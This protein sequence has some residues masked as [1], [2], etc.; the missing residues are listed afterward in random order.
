MEQAPTIHV[1]GFEIRYHKNRE[2]GAMDRPVE[3]VRYS[4]RFG[5]QSTE[6]SKP[7][8]HILP[9]EAKIGGGEQN[10]NMKLAFMRQRWNMIE[11]AYKAWKEGNELPL[12]GTPL[13]VWP[14]V[15]QQQATA[16]KN[17]G[18][19]TVEELRDMP[20]SQSGKVPLPNVRD[21]K[22]QA[23]AF[24]EATDKNAASTQMVELKSQNDALSDRLEA[25]MEMIEELSKAS[26]KSKPGRKPKTE[27]VDNPDAI[28][29]VE[30][31]KV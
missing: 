7:I 20:D 17:V 4:P 19:R 28:Q 16:L 6:V 3:Y 9:D 11:P 23:K 25:A 12:S 30:I 5:A 15:S 1:H 13:A 2:T 26:V 22:K 24:L 29:H 27:V 8:S 10:R 18:I 14:G 31:E 21:M